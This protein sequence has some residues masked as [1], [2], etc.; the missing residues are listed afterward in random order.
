M[1]CIQIP[2]PR[3]YSKLEKVESNKKFKREI[4]TRKVAWLLRVGLLMGNT[5]EERNK[6]QAEQRKSVFPKICVCLE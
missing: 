6:L 2:T 1:L 4:F 3:S 5:Y